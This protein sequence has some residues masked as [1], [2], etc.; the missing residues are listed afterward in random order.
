MA[1][2]PGAVADV[3]LRLVE[4]VDAEARA[5]GAD[6]DPL[7][8]RRLEL[9]Q[10]DRARARAGARPELA[11]LVDDRREERRVE[12]VVPRVPADDLVVGERIAEPLVPRRLRA[13]DVREAR[14]GD[15]EEPEERDRAPHDSRSSTSPANR[16]RSASE[17]SFTYAKSARRTFSSSG[18]SRSS[19]ASAT[20]VRAARTSGGAVITTTLSK[21][22]SPPVSYRSGTSTTAT[23]GGSGRRPSSSRHAAY[24]RT[25]LGWRSA[26]SASSASRSAKTTRARAA[27]SIA[28]EPSSTCEPKRSTTSRRTS[29][30]SAS[31]RW[32]ISSLDATSAPWRANAFRASLFP[33]PIPPVIATAIGLLGGRLFVDRGLGLGLGL[34]FGFGFRG[35]FFLGSRRGL[36]RE[37]VLREPEVRR[38]VDRLAAV[39]AR[40]RHRAVLDALQR[41][42]EPAPLRV[43]LEDE[44]VHGVALRDDLARVLDVVLRELGDVHEALDAREDLDEGAEGHHLRHLAFDL[45]AL[46]VGLQHLLPRIGL[47]LL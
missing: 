42:R 22:R 5:A 21:R 9:H 40:L 27:R 6:G 15:A 23:R 36:L 25:T 20:S 12:P 11:L 4:G 43:D 18:R 26:S 16:S 13:V 47:R 8:R 29:S 14:G 7:R 37:D 39:G 2:V 38:G 32:T 34:G 46:V 45:V 44:D 1:E 3:D 31:R 35:R 28:P 17:P 33:A 24:S 41:E 30:S 19:L 10:A